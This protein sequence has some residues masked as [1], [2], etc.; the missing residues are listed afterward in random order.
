[1]RENAINYL[2]SIQSLYKSGSAREHAYRPPFQALIEN[3]SKEIQVI[4]E[5]AYTGGNAP[6]F[7]FTKGNIPI[8]YAECKDINI[9]INS[10]S[11]QSQA[12]RYV[13]AFGKILLTNHY[14]FQ[15]IIENQEPIFFSIAKLENDKFI[16]DEENLEQKSKLNKRLS[17]P[18]SSYNPFFTKT[19]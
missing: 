3:I 14:Y 16:L 13:D 10:K 19:S 11:V 5:P 12:Q 15:I 9:D 7:L 18:H 8:S 2:N 6:D 1:M 4:N 17:L